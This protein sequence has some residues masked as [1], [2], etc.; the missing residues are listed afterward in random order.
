MFQETIV[1]EASYD[2]L[3]III[4]IFTKKDQSHFHRSQH[5]QHQERKQ[6]YHYHHSL[7]HL[8]GRFNL[9]SDATE[10][11]YTERGFSDDASDTEFGDDAKDAED[12]DS[13]VPDDKSESRSYD[14]LPTSTDMSNLII[15]MNGEVS[16]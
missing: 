12:D 10:V 13:Y 2:D 4:V 1:T 14:A 3:M 7:F 9:F 15:Q 11:A 8:G 6:H 5:W 16:G